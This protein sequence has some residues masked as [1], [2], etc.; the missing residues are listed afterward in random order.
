MIKNIIAKSARQGF[1]VL[2]VFAWGF[3][4]GDYF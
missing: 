2:V 1:L 3:V 4:E